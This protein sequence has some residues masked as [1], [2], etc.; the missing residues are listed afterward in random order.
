MIDMRPA[1]RR[2]EGADRRPEAEDLA[3]RGLVRSERQRHLFDEPLTVIDP[4]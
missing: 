2:S 4:T 1:A 3:R